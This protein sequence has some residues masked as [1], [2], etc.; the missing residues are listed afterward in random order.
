MSKNIAFFGTKPWEREHIEKQQAKLADAALWFTEE[1]LSDDHPPKETN[2]DAISVFV[3]SNVTRNVLEKFPILQFVATRST[4]FDHIDVAACKEK[5]IA[6]S[7]VPSYGAN[8]VAEMAFGLILTLSR[9]IY[10]SYDRIRETGNWS[11]EGL[12]GFDLM[13]KT[14]GIVGT[15]KI[16]R[17]S[18]AIAKGFGMK[19]VAYDPIPDLGLAAEYNFPYKPLNDLLAESDVVTIHVP[20]MTETHHLMDEKRIGLMKKGALLINTS[21]GG[22]VETAALVRALQSGQLGGAGLDVLEEEGVIKDEIDFLV[23]GKPE[24]H[25]WKTVIANHVLIDMPNVVITP[26]NAF[27]T[28]EAIERILDTTVENIA[29]YLRGEVLNKVNV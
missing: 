11:V 13:G 18:I 2:F 5:N 10:E 25:D 16:G 6:V 28:K 15:G 1:I 29:G 14:I 9:K 17:H 23:S 7:S 8:T 3:D 12:R 26:H 24:G 27:N 21:R 22:I 19:I 20:Y 4:G